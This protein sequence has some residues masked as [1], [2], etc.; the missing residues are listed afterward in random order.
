[1]TV[2]IV[3]SIV[4]CI[5]MVIFGIYVAITKDFILVSGVNQTTFSDKHKP[6]IAYIF[7][8]CIS[9]SAIFLMFTVLSFEY[10][11]IVLAF[12]FLAI[13]LLLIALFYVCF[14]KITKYP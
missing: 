14:Y 3:F 1:M 6:K 9:L 2:N 8:L 12:V 13:A 10:D 4:I 5:S 11:Y 7:G